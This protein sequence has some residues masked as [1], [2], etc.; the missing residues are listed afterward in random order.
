MADSSGKRRIKLPGFGLPVQEMPSILGYPSDNDNDNDDDDGDDDDDAEIKDVRI[1]LRFPHAIADGCTSR[2]VTLN[3]RRMLAFINQ[4]TDKPNWEEKV[5]NEEIVGKWRQEASNQEGYFGQKMFDYC[6]QE[7]RE[8]SAKYKETGMVAVCDT[9]ATVVK[10]DTAVPFELR[11]A[12]RAAVAPLENVPDRLKDWHPSSHDKVLDLVHPSLYPLV[13]GKS[14]V[15]PFGK[16]PLNTC[17]KYSGA[18]ELTRTWVADDDDGSWDQF[19]W[20]PS[21][22]HFTEGG[23]VKISSYINNLHPLHYGGLYGI[24]EQMVATVVP[25]WNE[26]LSWFQDRIRIDVGRTDDEDW[27]RP[28]EWQSPGWTTPTDWD[29][30]RDGEYDKMDDDDYRDLYEDWFRRVRILKQPEPDEYMPFSESTKRSGACPIDLREKF[31]D[32]G[33]QIIFKLANIHLDPSKP[34]YDG[35]TWHI[36]GALNEHICATAIYYY[37][38]ENITD[39]HL[40]FRQAIDEEEM[41]MKPAQSEF[42]SCEEY[43]G[44]EDQTSGTLIQVLGSVLTRQDRLL[45]FPNVLQHHVSPFSLADAT[46]PGYRKILAMFLVDPH[47]RVLS[48]ANVLPQ[49][50]DWWAEEVQ[51]IKPFAKLPVEV[52]DHIISFVDDPWSLEEAK[53]IREQLMDQRGRMNDDINDGIED[54]NVSFCEH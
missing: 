27:E 22:V 43:Y 29:E 9:T 38:Q 52:F 40:S 12:L 45:V 37:D 42:K 39:S 23:C 11:D 33:L 16:V 50:R 15:L 6:I 24:L 53:R 32:S 1:R 36:E 46:K 31:K 8:K 26:S 21:D 19:Q 20:L 34:E 13:Y 2:G 28:E 18:G 3:E 35:G 4:V 49:Q 10:S 17:A 48:T 41:L 14:K 54:A 51:Q 30:D 25:L 47:I 44:V 7:L 5:F